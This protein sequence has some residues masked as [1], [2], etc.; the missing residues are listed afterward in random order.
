MNAPATISAKTQFAVEATSTAMDAA[1]PYIDS[2]ML[3]LSNGYSIIQDLMPLF[4]LLL[5]LMMLRWNR[6]FRELSR[7]QEQQTRVLV[8]L[9]NLHP[10][11][12]YQK[13]LRI[14]E[15]RADEREA[16]RQKHPHLLS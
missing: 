16:R 2:V 13:F 10:D 14:A 8:K 15:Q 1:R 3:I 4:V 11:S 12:D 7:R 5:F 9:L 6:Q